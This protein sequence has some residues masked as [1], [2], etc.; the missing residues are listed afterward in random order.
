MNIGS[1]NRRVPIER[2]VS[3]QGPDGAPFETWEFA[4]E[5]WANI[6]RLSGREALKDARDVSLVRASIHI[7][8]GLL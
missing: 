5:V 4:A 1:F 3:T 6:R 2:P 8:M 7:A